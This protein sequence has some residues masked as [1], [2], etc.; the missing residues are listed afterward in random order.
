MKDT[1]KGHEEIELD[2]D[3]ESALDA[4]WDKL[5]SDADTQNDG[6]K[7]DDP[8]GKPSKSVGKALA[9]CVIQRS[10]GKYHAPT[11]NNANLWSANISRA[12]WYSPQSAER[13][14]A[15]FNAGESMDAA[16]AGRQ[17]YSYSIEEPNSKPSKSFRQWCKRWVAKADGPHEFSSTQF[18]LEGYERS[19]A[20]T[21]ANQID[22]A[23]LTIKGREETPHI[24]VRYGLE[25]SNAD[26]VREIVETFG[27]VSMVLGDVDY[28]PSDEYDVVVIRVESE[29]LHRLNEALAELPHVDTHDE[30][31][32]HV[33]L[34]YV[35]PGCGQKYVGMPDRGIK[36]NVLEYSQLVFSP[37]DG[38]PTIIDIASYP[39]QE[40]GNLP[41]K[42]LVRKAVDRNAVIWWSSIGQAER[43]IWLEEVTPGGYLGASQEQMLN[44]PLNGM[45]R[46]QASLARE[47]HAVALDRHV[48]GK[49][50][51]RNKKLCSKG[52]KEDYDRIK[53]SI[54]ST[55]MG[56]LRTA[57][58]G[59]S[60]YPKDEIKDVLIELGYTSSGSKGNDLKRLMDNVTSLKISH[61]QTNQIGKQKRFDPGTKVASGQ[62]GKGTVVEQADDLAV[63]KWISGDETVEQVKDLNPRTESK[64]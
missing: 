45:D 62:R 59:L 57:M 4:A 43:R 48:H 22:D 58:S 46:Y 40:A 42:G 24:T 64:P 63:V 6:G 35:N 12:Y 49:L 50:L 29:D 3:E 10:D 39:A 54:P 21:K 18:N 41:S 36:G 53:Q 33:T 51:V 31:Q 20:L 9:S 14:L 17:Q 13:Q 16:A 11:M 1:E 37:K 15:K 28:F 32:P 56:G 8:N 26:Q 61:S 52:A 5:D 23:D 27:S 30:Y 34:A 25:T 19:L 47:A 38:T 55:D 44:K 2:E 60:K 7:V